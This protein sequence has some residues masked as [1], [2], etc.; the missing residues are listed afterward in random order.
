M[1][2]VA[3]L[4]EKLKSAGHNW[5][6]SVKAPAEI[7]AKKVEVCGAE[8]RSYGEAT[9][10]EYTTYSLL[11]ESQRR[12]QTAYEQALMQVVDKIRAIVPT[13]ALENFT[14]ETVQENGEAAYTYSKDETAAAVATGNR[15]AIAHVWSH[16][17]QIMF[18]LPPIFA[19]MKDQVADESAATQELSDACICYFL[20][21]RAVSED[22]KIDID[23]IPNLR[24]STLNAYMEFYQSELNPP[25]DEDEPKAKKR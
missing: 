1:L 22:F 17:P 3:F 19:A 9:I 6:L 25:K 2:Y 8:F 11:A 24:P 13:E 5:A 4:Q 7:G 20:N 15:D 21:S 18:D 10:A 23:D 12:N 14:P 16:Y